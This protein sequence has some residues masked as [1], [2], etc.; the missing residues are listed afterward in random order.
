MSS[1]ALRASTAPAVGPA[2]DLRQWENFMAVVW[3]TLLFGLGAMFGVLA[4]GIDA[5]YGMLQ[6]RAMQN[7]ADA[8]AMAAAKLASGS[9]VSDG[10]GG[11]IFTIPNGT[12]YEKARE[13]A[14]Y[15]H[16]A[17]LA[18]SNFEHLAVQ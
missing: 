2:R 17:G 10:A 8:G 4:L 12:V 9:V 7:G 5:G 13:F 18:S 15:N 11:I 16:P 14:F 6:V 1:R 3:V